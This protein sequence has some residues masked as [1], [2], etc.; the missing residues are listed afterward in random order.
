MKQVYCK[1][2]VHSSHHCRDEHPVL[3]LDLL[4]LVVRGRLVGRVQRLELAD[5]GVPL[6]DE[7]AP[8]PV[9]ALVDAEA[10][11][12]VDGLRGGTSVSRVGRDTQVGAAQLDGGL[13]DLHLAQ[14]YLLAL[15]V[16]GTG[17]DQGGQLK[18]REINL[19]SKVVPKKT[20][21]ALCPDLQSRRSGLCRLG[22][23]QS[24]SPSRG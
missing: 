9:L 12:V 3:Q 7:P 14:V 20:R 19:E 18:E 6:V 16:H 11:V 22:C 15:L 17:V 10:L 5:G 13:L 21:Q 23:L 4:E 1:P 24:Q 2:C 8:H